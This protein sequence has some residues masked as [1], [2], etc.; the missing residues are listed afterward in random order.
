PLKTP[1]YK[2][3]KGFLLWGVHSCTSPLRLQFADVAA[4]LN[5]VLLDRELDV[6][7]PVRPRPGHYFRFCP[8]NDCAPSADCSIAYSRI[9]SHQQ[10]RSIGIF[11]G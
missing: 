7:G 1:C 10:Q 8:P 11:T 5:S 3:S 6:T 4:H 9:H 2:R